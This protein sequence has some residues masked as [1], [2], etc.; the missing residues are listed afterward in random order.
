MKR[1][2]A[3][4]ALF[5]FAPGYALACSCTVVPGGLQELVERSPVVAVVR[6]TSAE[7]VPDLA[8]GTGREAVRAKFSVVE[9]LK[10]DAGSVSG[11]NTSHG[12]CSLP[13]TIGDAYLVFA[14][15]HGEAAS[16]DLC[17]SARHLDESGGKRQDRQLLAIR[18]YLTR[19]IAIP[20]CENWLGI[21]PPPGNG[22]DLCEPQ[23]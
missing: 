13:V 2:Q 16:L 7:L 6:V 5:A 9:N 14:Q 20:K 11:L 22:V 17:S 15:G 23:P 18:N 4:M 1:I 10:G 8:L 12:S 19:R 3:S 21:P